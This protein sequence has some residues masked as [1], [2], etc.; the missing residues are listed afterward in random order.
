MILSADSNSKDNTQSMNNDNSE[1]EQDAKSGLT[2]NGGASNDP[3]RGREDP[4]PPPFG[5]DS[6]GI[7]LEP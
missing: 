5:C 2:L 1:S 4:T 6:N 7:C 3:P